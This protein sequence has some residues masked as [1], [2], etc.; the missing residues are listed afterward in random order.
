MASKD[1]KVAIVGGGLCG[2]ACA[3]ALLKDGVDVD[4]YEAAEKFGDVG[5]GVGQG[6]NALHVLEALG[7]LDDVREQAAL[8]AG[9]VSQGQYHNFSN[10]GWFKFVSGL[11]GHEVLLDLTF[12]Q[13]EAERVEPG[14]HRAVLVDALS[15]HIPAGR[16][17]FHKRCVSISQPS[18][19][20]PV[21]IRFVDGTTASADV[22]LGTDGLKSIVR[23]FTTDTFGV[24]PDPW[25]KFSNKLCFRTLFPASKAV[26]AGI[27]LDFHDRPICYV[28]KSNHIVAF[29]VKNG[30]IINVVASAE[31]PDAPAGE[32]TFTPARKHTSSEELLAMYADWGSE[33]RKLL[34][35]GEGV[36]KWNI[37]VVYPHLPPEKWTKG[38]VAILGDAAHAMLPHLG[39]GAG[40]GFE[41]AY[42]VGKLLGD[43]RTNLSN[44]ESV[45]RAYATVRQ[46]RAQKVWEES[47]RVAD[48]YEERYDSINGEELHALWDYVWK[49]KLD[50]DVQR[51]RQ[52]LVTE[53]I[54]EG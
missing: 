35:C 51:V 21:T 37:N 9:P 19:N 8:S 22:V 36:T 29:T 20:E 6:A 13:Y 28:G 25:L 38:R 40:Q 26:E 16:K 14:F 3:I 54:F 23:R 24:D 45:L 41:D 34:A 2:L 31:S 5:G 1:F 42:L 53:G 10:T 46:P 47:K 32:D 52:L 50:D 4:V 30:S 27:T 43:P 39:A 49:Y 7:V 17:H 11:E 44:L 15:K 12:S 48:I 18:S 33:V